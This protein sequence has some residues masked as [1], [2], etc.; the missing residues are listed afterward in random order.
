M[1]ELEDLRQR[2]E[3]LE[4]FVSLLTESVLTQGNQVERVLGIVGLLT[5]ENR[6][7]TRAFPEVVR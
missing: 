5:Q 2:V 7:R 4:R 6:A 1:T 3:D